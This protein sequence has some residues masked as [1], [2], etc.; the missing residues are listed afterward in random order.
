MKPLCDPYRLRHIHL[1]EP[2]SGS[3]WGSAVGTCALS[4]LHSEG[5]YSE[6]TEHESA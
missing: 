3:L 6:N 4:E 5:N 2:V 1:G